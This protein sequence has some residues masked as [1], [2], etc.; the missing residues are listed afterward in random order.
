MKF[1]YNTRGTCSRQIILDI[2]DDVL[3]SV[4]FVGGCNGNLKGI[5]S[6]CKGME[7]DE[8]IANVELMPLLDN[9]FII[10][11]MILTKPTFNIRVSEKGE[12]NWSNVGGKGK[13]KVGNVEVSF[14]DVKLNNSTIS[15]INAQNSEEFELPN[16]SASVSASSLKGPYKADGKLL[17][18]KNEIKFA[19]NVTNNNGIK[20]NFNISNNASNTKATIEGTLGEKADGLITFETKN[21]EKIANI[22]WGDNMEGEFDSTEEKIINGIKWTVIGFFLLSLIAWILESAL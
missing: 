18:N 22:I 10:T 8:I 19:G 20:L 17:Y 15:Y 2:E 4:E 11:S 6:L 12:M 3:Q 21:F 14:K 7:I 13:N 1:T 5:S 9:K 16:I